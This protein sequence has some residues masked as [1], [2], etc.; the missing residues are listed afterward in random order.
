MVLGTM[1]GC[2]ARPLL[3]TA[4]LVWLLMSLLAQQCATG[5]A[6]SQVGGHD[7]PALPQPADAGYE[8]LPASFVAVD[9]STF[10]RAGEDCHSGGPS[11]ALCALASI[12]ALI[13]APAAGGPTALNEVPAVPEPG[14][15]SHVPHPDT[16]PPRS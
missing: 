15:R 9:A 13:H 16:P 8:S 6:F 7:R 5:C 10:W 4:T 12:P 11:A 2:L 1:L 3:I 14:F